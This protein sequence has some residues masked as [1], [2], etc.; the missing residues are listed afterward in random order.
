MMSAVR[1]SVHVQYSSSHQ[2]QLPGWRRLICCV[3]ACTCRWW[4]CTRIKGLSAEEA[5]QVRAKVACLEVL[6]GQ[7]VDLG[8]QRAWEGNYLVSRW[9]VSLPEREKTYIPGELALR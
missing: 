4:A 3:V 5:L 8:L 7:R 9:D 6:K 2:A 1:V